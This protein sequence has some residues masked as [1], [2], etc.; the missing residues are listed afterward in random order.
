MKISKKLKS[1]AL[2]V[3]F[4]I[5]YFWVIQK[6]FPKIFISSFFKEAFDVLF[7]LILEGKLL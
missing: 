3:I 4:Q 5:G 7:S 6:F 1:N 2:N